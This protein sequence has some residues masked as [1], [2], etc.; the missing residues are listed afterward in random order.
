MSD[1]FHQW[2]E[3][4]ARRGYFHC[5]RAGCKAQAA[6]IACVPVRVPGCHRIRCRRHLEEQRAR[7]EAMYQRLTAPLHSVLPYSF[8]R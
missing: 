6:C 3:Y 7:D 5:S 8:W 1:H 4:R 2:V